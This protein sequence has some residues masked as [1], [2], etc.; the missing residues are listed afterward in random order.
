MDVRAGL[1]AAVRGLGLAMLSMVCSLVLFC[2]T[3]VSLVLLPLGLGVLTTPWVT[4]VARAN[5][6]LRRLL[7]RQWCGV[8]IEVP[9]RPL[10][11][12]EGGLVG[13]VQRCRWL[14]R[15]PATWRDLTWMIVDPVAGF[16][17][18]I[19]AL[20]L[21]GYGALGFVLAAGLWW[22]LRDVGYWYGFVPVDDQLS[23]LA[24][25]GL[26]A[27]LIALGV[28]YDPALL[29]VHGLLTRAFLAPTHERRLQMRI[30]RLQESRAD[31]VDVS[32]AELRRIERDLHDGAQAR[33]VAVGMSLGTIEH[34]LRTNPEKAAQLV[35]ETRRSSVE[36]LEELRQLVRGIHPP[37]LAERGLG[38]A[39]RA[40]A[41]RS[42]VRCE[43][44]IGPIGRM[45]AP[46]EAAAYFSVSE[47]LTNVAKHARASRAWID[48]RHQDGM[49]RITVIDDG[50]GGADP[51]GGSGLT[52]IERRLGA[53]DGSLSVTSPPGGP[54][55]AVI[56]LP[57]G[58]PA[59][60][61]RPSSVQQP[62]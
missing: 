14:L 50:R 48:M 36:A 26:G 37:V 45:A 35:A 8:D 5:A 43:V 59:P 53:F 27:V 47:M 44:D 3:V 11:P 62:S 49:L 19:L 13:Q 57:S 51:A 6:D 1:M 30:E 40:L 4:H 17:L 23:A 41:L 2:L 56:E 9:Y 32:A 28:R 55:T 22:P 38:D 58:V 16:T 33:L 42:P 60:P 31:A 21:V 7:A 29:R 52:G 10:P 25:A 24:A 34:L 61:A 54:T 20:G 39:V 18:G 15:D 12:V 46:V